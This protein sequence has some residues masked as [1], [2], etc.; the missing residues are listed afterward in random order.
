M[1]SIASAGHAVDPTII[2]TKK[3]RD[4]SLTMSMRKMG[5]AGM[6][7][8]DEFYCTAEK[9]GW[10]RIGSNIYEEVLING[11]PTNAYRIRSTIEEYLYEARYPV[12]NPKG[13]D[14]FTSKSKLLGRVRK[15]LEK[16]DNDDRFPTLERSQTQWSFENGIYCGNTDRFWRYDDVLTYENP[17]SPFVRGVASARFIAL[18]FP[19]KLMQN[20]YTCHPERINVDSFRQ[21]FDAQQF[22]EEQIKWIWILIGRLYH[23]V[24][25]KDDWNVMLWLKGLA[26]TGKSTIL[27]AIANAYELSD[28]VILGNTEEE[29]EEKDFDLKIL[30]GKFLI[31]ASDMTQSVDEDTFQTMV[32]GYGHPQMIGISNGFPN[33]WVDSEDAIMPR[34]MGLCFKYSIPPDQRD[35]RLDERALAD[36]PSII[37]KANRHYLHAVKHYSNG[38][39]VWSIVAPEFRR[40]LGT[41]TRAVNLLPAFIDFVLVRTNAVDDTVDMDEFLHLFESWVSFSGITMRGRR[42]Y[43]F[44]DVASTLRAFDDLH[45]EKCGPSESVVRGCRLN[46]LN[47][48][49]IL[50]DAEW[51]P[52]VSK[53][54]LP[55]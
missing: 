38:E 26:G 47:V 45:A 34:V 33:N 24:G 42:A 18:E 16:V 53:V 55:R 17:F 46:L 12:E 6:V 51:F 43:T 49:K 27:R 13:I 9:K 40:P 41:V 35:T 48:Y 2:T 4:H 22:S 3:K 8:L 7:V 30:R 14:A 36:L 28:V 52:S 54:S 19:E 25:S 29:E 5:H 20:P 39:D 21:I 15:H 11:Y 37:V 1:A 23:P 44:A 50:K 31:S 10:R 32:D